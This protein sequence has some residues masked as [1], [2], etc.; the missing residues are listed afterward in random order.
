MCYVICHIIF[1]LV[2]VAKPTIFKVK[3]EEHNYGE[4]KKKR[5]KT[6]PKLKIQIK[7]FKPWCCKGLKQQVTLLSNNAIQSIN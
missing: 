5:C 7:F 1:G 3:K 2:V 6:K 4:S